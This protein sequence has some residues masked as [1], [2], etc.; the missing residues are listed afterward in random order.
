PL[1]PAS[2]AEV[3]ITGAISWEGN[4]PE[5]PGQLAVK[6]PYDAGGGYDIDSMTLT[7]RPGSGTYWLVSGQQ[8]AA[9]G[10]AYAPVMNWLRGFPTVAQT[11]PEG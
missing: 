3:G 4:L 11:Y 6:I 8:Y 7:V 9:K 1:F 10:L 2:S 5:L